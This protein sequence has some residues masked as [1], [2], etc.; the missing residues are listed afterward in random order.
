GQAT[1]LKDQYPLWLA[2]VQHAGQTKAQHE[3]TIKRFM[4][5]AS[6]S[7]SIEEVTRKKAGEYVTDLMNTS[8]FARAT[9]RRHVSSLSS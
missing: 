6:D 4:G 1:L 7:V 3:S 9:A 5:W 2:E 8:G